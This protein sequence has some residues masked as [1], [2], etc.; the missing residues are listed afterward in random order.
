MSAPS[1]VLEL[2]DL[3]RRNADAYQ[4]LLDWHRDRYL[5]DGP[6]KHTKELYQGAGG[7]WRLTTAEKKRILLA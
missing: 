4:R 3:F 1:K 7:Q 5:E 6:K 2:V